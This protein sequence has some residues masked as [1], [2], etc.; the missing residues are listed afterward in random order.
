MSELRSLLS[1]LNQ[2]KVLAGR[3]LNSSVVWSWIYN[4]FRLASG[5][6]LL[7]LILNELSTDELGMYYVLLSQVALS[8]VIDFGFSPT[9]SRFVGFAMGG[10]ESIQAHGVAKT[11]AAGPNYRLLWELLF[12]TRA[13]YRYL[14]LIV[15]AV[16]AVWGT[17]LVEMRIDS[18]PSPLI[19]RIAWIATILSTALDIYVSWAIVFLR[20]MNEILPSTRIG[21]AAAMVRFFLSAG[22]LMAG[23]GLL[24]IPLGGLAGSI[25]QQYL[26]RRLCLK[27]MANH[28]APDRVPIA[29]HLRVLWPNS[30]RTGV[31]LTSFYLTVN[32]NTAICLYLL[33]LGA[34]AQYGLSIQLVN[35]IAGMSAVWTYVKWPLINQY[36]TRHDY[37]ALQHIFWPRVWLQNLTFLA[38]AGGLLLLGPFLL[39][40]FG[41]GKQMLPLFWM[42]LLVLNS[43]LESQFSLWGTL[44]ST[45]NR[46]PYLWPAVATNVA[47][48][49]LSLVLIRTTDLGLGAFVLGPLIPGL[50]FNYWY[51]P[52]AGARSIQTSW[53]R[54]TFS[55]PS[56]T[57][58]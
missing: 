39:R 17:Y 15:I 20:G 18:T 55:G 23:A 24:S 31:Q 14:S 42:G 47:S 57:S 8:T 43:F 38:M 29:K 44:I 27:R 52:L 25:L 28:P 6:L 7:P 11:E 19:T 3:L 33:G 37:T 49:A 40:T 51:W 50:L 34:N 46:Q 35:I 5:L 21:V 12:T 56:R 10:A 45:E 9:I 30:W 4:L 13:L 53:L 58:A 22:L 32:G 16:M 48:L 41:S 2:P 54:F 36:R 1:S 26:T